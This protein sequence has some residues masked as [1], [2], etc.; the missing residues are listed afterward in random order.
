ML[1]KGLV[2]TVAMLVLDGLWINL[3]MGPLYQEKLSIMQVSSGYRLA[4][5]LVFAYG[6]MVIGLFTFVLQNDVS[7]LKA[8]LFGCILYGVFSFTNMV[9]FSK[10]PIL[11]VIADTVWGSFLYW[12][13]WCLAKWVGYLN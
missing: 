6:L 5:A 11:L 12:I 3:F 9:I 10:W 13:L 2:L 4:T 1:Y 7:A 8:A